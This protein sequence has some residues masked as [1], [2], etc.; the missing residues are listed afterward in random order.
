ME[1]NDILTE[2]FLANMEKN[3]PNYALFR[4]DEQKTKDK[5]RKWAVKIE[6]EA[7]ARVFNSEWDKF[8]IYFTPNWEYRNRETRIEKEWGSI[9]CFHADIDLWWDKKGQREWFFFEPTMVNETKNWYH[10]FWMLK[11]PLPE[12]KRDERKEIEK[13]ISQEI[14]WD[15]KAVDWSRIL[16]VPWYRYW[17]DWEGTFII[18]TIF[19][20]EENTYDF[21]YIKDM[22]T[23]LNE[24]KMTTTFDYFKKKSSDTLIS[25]I[26]F[27]CDSMRADDMLMELYPRFTV[28]WGD[29][30]ENWHKTN[31]YRYN[32]VE[33]YIN[34]FSRDSIHD[35]PKWWP[36]NILMEHFGWYTKDSIKSAAEY[37][38]Q[39]HWKKMFT[40]AKEKVSDAYEW[41]E[42]YM[43]NKDKEVA[44]KWSK[45]IIIEAGEN[46]IRIER[47]NGKVYKKTISTGSLV[48]IIDW[49]IRC[50]WYFM[51]NEET[52]NYIITYKKD[53]KTTG[54]FTAKLLGKEWAFSVFLSKVWLTFLW[55]KNDARQIISYIHRQTTVFEY[56]DK[57]GI[58]DDKLV[59]RKQG[60]FVDK[61]NWK[62]LYINIQGLGVIWDGEL[63]NLDESIEEK[64]LEEFRND[65]KKL[66]IMYE[67]RIVYTA[68][69]HLAMSLFAKKLR[70]EYNYFP[71][72][73]FVWL[74][75]SGKTTL[76][77]T[78][79]KMLWYSDKTEIGGSSTEFVWMMRAKHY[80]PMFVWEYDSDWLKF[81]TD[82]FLKL[83]Y[84]NQKIERGRANQTL[85]V[86]EN[87]APIV[88]DGETRSITNSVVTRSILLSMRPS[89]RRKELKWVQNISKY[90]LDNYCLIDSFWEKLSKRKEKFEEKTEK[91]DRQEKWRLIYNYSMLMSFADCFWFVDIVWQ[92]IE[93]QLMNHIGQLGDDNQI[94]KLQDIIMQSTLNTIE[95]KFV[96]NKMDLLIFFDH[97][98]VDTKKSKEFEAQISI[99]N[100]VFTPW[101][102]HESRKLTVPL[103]YIYKHKQLH[104][105]FNRLL[106]ILSDKW[107][108][109]EY[110]WAT[111]M[112]L[113]IFCEENSF[114]NHRYYSDLRD[115]FWFDETWEKKKKSNKDKHENTQSLDTNWF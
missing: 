85:N 78:L 51:D 43:P 39:K 58:Y 12:W 72:L 9:F 112:W 35:R 8:W 87:N 69:T 102:L 26:F 28:K 5:K 73:W 113:K 96:D 33:N 89:F 59:I 22:M 17:K 38:E 7:K 1:N 64:S 37:L 48:P 14:W 114:T 31:W 41:K 74:T 44:T 61:Y 100:D 90:F 94:K 109:D 27:E 84:D 115:K 99:L 24:T 49:A 56:I 50:I 25:K 42:P 65:I 3:F 57:L 107:K 103:E 18:K 86:Y 55:S 20:N 21:S 97:M 15:P 19:I 81:D 54:F 76:R 67:E 71:L 83:N 36:V 80:I 29:I 11:E 70:N 63:F 60:N 62:F 95:C 111:R 104:W 110:D 77:R 101:D 108:L 6:D 52:K 34:N 93:A 23:S 82:N 106:D 92:Y 98:K 66:S 88:I 45:D 46:E 13:W 105:T 10:C 2:Q 4:L 75:Q 68:F 79:C 30:Y 16:R 32:K 91:I 40:Y 47:D 53:E